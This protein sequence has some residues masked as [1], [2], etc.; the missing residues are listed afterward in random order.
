MIRGIRQVVSSVV[1]TV[2]SIVETTVKVVLTTVFAAVL[3]V[4]A[5]AVAPTI[6]DLVDRGCDT[7]LCC[8]ECVSIAVSRVIDGDTFVSG[9]GRVRLYGIDAP[10]VGQRCSSEAT[11]RLRELVGET[12]RVE[13]GPRP[14]DRFDRTLAYIYTMKGQS[15]DEKLVREGLAVAW[16]QDGQHRDF[17]ISI[18]AEARSTGAGCLW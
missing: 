8:E 1:R 3:F 18:E 4:G 5:L 10:E 7:E 2:R 17:L 13:P 12:V 11:E 16:T 15:A 9:K 14:R 6:I